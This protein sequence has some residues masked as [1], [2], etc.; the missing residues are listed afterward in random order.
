MVFG[1]RGAADSLEPDPI[2]VGSTDGEGKGDAGPTSGAQTA[3]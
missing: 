1:G 3:P 2:G